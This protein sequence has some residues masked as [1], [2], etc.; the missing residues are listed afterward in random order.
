[1]N[2]NLQTISTADL[3]KEIKRRQKEGPKP[4]ESPDFSKVMGMVLDL[5]H[6][7]QQDEYWSD[8]N[9]HY[10]FEA[11]MEAIYGPDF[12]DWWNSKGW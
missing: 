6:N 7:A 2:K 12:F 11:V 4:I 5:L 8:D 1:M 10:I 3:L 9:D